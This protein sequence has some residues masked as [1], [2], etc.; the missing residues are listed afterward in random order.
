MS[1]AKGALGLLTEVPAARRLLGGT[2]H[3]AGW[4]R[5]ELKSRE[6]RA[7]IPA[8]RKRKRPAPRNRKHYKK[9]RRI[10]NALARLKDWRGLATPDTR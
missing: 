7:C 9:P 10:E 5:D 1:D 8:R 3:D 2:G 6:V 4:L